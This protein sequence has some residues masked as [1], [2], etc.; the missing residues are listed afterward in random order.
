MKWIERVQQQ[1]IGWGSG[2]GNDIGVYV[3]DTM[4]VKGI[5]DVEYI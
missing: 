4:Y 5:L 1:I 2:F 3:T